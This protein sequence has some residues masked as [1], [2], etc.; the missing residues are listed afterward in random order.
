MDDELADMLKTGLGLFANVLMAIQQ[1][2]DGKPYGS[3]GYA[4]RSGQDLVAIAQKLPKLASKYMRPP[5]LLRE[6]N[7]TGHWKVGDGRISEV[8]DWLTG[9][10][11]LR[12]PDNKGGNSEYVGAALISGNSGKLLLTG[13]NTQNEF[14]IIKCDATDSNMVGTFWFPHFPESAP[15]DIKFTRLDRKRS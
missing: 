13:S 9:V 7:L 15:Q 3:V 5:T 14:A 6:F 10:I 4:S 11:Q 1:A 2:K 8:F 12:V